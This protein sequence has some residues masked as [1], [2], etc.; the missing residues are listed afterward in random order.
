MYYIKK[1]YLGKVKLV[2][3][4]EQLLLNDEA[5]QEQL[6]SWFDDPT[7]QKYIDYNK[8]KKDDAKAGEQTD[9]S[10]NKSSGGKGS[11]KK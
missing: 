1:K 2:R 10:E 9:D 8:T 7:A 5:T 4:A 11:K 3:G 6:E